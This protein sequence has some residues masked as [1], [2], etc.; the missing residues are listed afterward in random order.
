MDQ[1]IDEWLRLKRIAVV[2][3]E[4]AE[5]KTIVD[6]L[7]TRG[8]NAR[9]VDLSDA[10]PGLNPLLP[11]DAC[12]V[13]VT[14]SGA[15]AI[16]PQTIHLIGRKPTV[17][18]CDKADPG[19]RAFQDLEAIHDFAV[20]PVNLDELMI[21]I[22]KVARDS[23]SPFP[24]PSA[25]RRA[26]VVDDEETIS[27]LLSAILEQ[28]GFACQVASTAQ[29]MRDLA[30]KSAFDVVLLDILM[31]GTDGFAMLSDL[32]V[33]PKTSRL[34][35]I[36]VSSKTAEEDIERGF[37]LGA[38]DYVTKPFNSRELVAR[39]ERAVSRI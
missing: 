38:D 16:A 7:R 34:P 13:N 33:S 5:A 29:Q 20:R 32:R 28:A 31:P 36:V 11:Y 14:R 18:I 23:E 25:R 8:L 3:F 9:A 22:A 15:V 21:R 30:R 1:H 27:L 2:S 4:A 12:V 24:A 6:G 10:L 39:V 17:M 35:I 19:D 26:L 37:K